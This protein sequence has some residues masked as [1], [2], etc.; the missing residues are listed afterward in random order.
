LR[1]LNDAFLHDPFPTPFTDE[2]LEN[3]GGQEAYSF[4]DGFSGY[5]QIRIAPEDRHKTTF[6][7]EWGSFQYTVMPFGLKNAPAIFSR[8]VV[9]SFKDFIHK[10]LEVYLDDWTMFSLLKDHVAVLRLML[11]RCRQCQISLNIKKCI[12]SAPFGILLGHVVCKQGLLVDPAKI[13][14]I[15]NLPP[16]KSVHQLKS[17]LGHTGYYKKFIR[18]YAQITAPMEKLLKKDIKYQWNDECQKS[19]DILKEKMV[20]APIL[21]FPD[22]SKE[23]HVHV[24]ASAIALG[25]VLTQPGEGDIDHPIAF[26]KQEVVRFREELQ[27]YRKR[28]SSYGLCIAEIQTLLVRTTLQDVYRSFFS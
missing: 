5:H 26:C 23:F 1:K 22:W 15:V 3:V 24:D 11:D 18:G 19:L 8:V 2:V 12:F 25:A 7:T 6:A 14:V 4:T 27:Y 28:R 17:T 13:V 10:F 9:A 16:P 21:V 20:T